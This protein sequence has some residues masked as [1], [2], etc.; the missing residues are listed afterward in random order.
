MTIG[1]TD[2]GT[3]SPAQSV[4]DEPRRW[5]AMGVSLARS[6]QT[7]DFGGT[8]QDVP[9]F[10][11]LM[12]EANKNTLK[13]YLMSTVKPYGVVAITPDSG[14]DLG[15]GASGSVSLIFMNFKAQWVYGTSWDV[16]LLFRRY[17]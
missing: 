17:T 3:R 15:I 2:Y 10:F 4:V 11:Q 5:T 9:V 12:T 14:D 8:E 7:L 6:V 1:G 16:S 13:S